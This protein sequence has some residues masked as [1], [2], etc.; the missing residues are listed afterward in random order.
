M[1]KK[2]MKGIEIEGGKRNV[3]AGASASVTIA[4][5]A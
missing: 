1:A 5:S 2:K 3:K 4:A